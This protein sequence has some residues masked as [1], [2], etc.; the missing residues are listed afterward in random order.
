[1][2]LFNDRQI[3][4]RVACASVARAH[5]RTDDLCSGAFPLG[6]ASNLPAATPAA[7]E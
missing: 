1:M 3:T 4:L 6:L 7:H 5:P 2:L